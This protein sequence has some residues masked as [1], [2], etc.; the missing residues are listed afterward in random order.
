VGGDTAVI[1]APS[2]QVAGRAWVFARSGSDWEQQQKL[3]PLDGHAGDWFGESVATHGSRV[4]VGAFLENVQQE[5]TGAAYVFERVGARW[6]E[7]AKLTDPNGALWDRFGGAA[8][9]D[10]DR[11]LIGAYNDDDAGGNGGSGFVFTATPTAG[12]P[13][14]FGD[15]SG[16]PC[17]C[18]NE[19]TAGIGVGCA[20]S[21][22][23][24]A[25][26]S[27]FG[28][29]SVA[30]DDLTL[31]GAPLLSGQAALLFAA[32]EEVNGG[33]GVSFGD[34]LRCAGTNVL[35]LGVEF[36][37][38]HHGFA[39]WG[40]GLGAGGGWAPGETRRFQVWYRDSTGS[41]CGSN[42]NLSNAIAIPFTP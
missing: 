1:G 9:M 30:T 41:P 22:G 10:G 24:G 2:D 8:S 42:F 3:R 34:G 5:D 14:C 33:D 12:T 15:G 37:D 35:R 27:A 25:E 28:S 40:P 4:V 18:G 29:A 7:N 39:Y 32:D 31:R 17:P 26:L 23:L 13:Y 36:P 6:Y 20:H 19:S 11:I 38:L 16:A 21:G